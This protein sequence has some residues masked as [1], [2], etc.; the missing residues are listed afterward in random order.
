MQIRSCVMRCSRGGGAVGKVIAGGET[1]ETGE[2]PQ[3]HVTDQGCVNF[4]VEPHFPFALIPGPTE[5]IPKMYRVM[6]EHS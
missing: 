1:G 2:T 5:G 3:R 6:R 4:V